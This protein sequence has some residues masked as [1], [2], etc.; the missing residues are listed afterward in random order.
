VLPDVATSPVRV[1]VERGR[2]VHLA[3]LGEGAGWVE[4]PSRGDDHGVYPPMR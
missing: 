3:D 4:R 2:A 1:Y